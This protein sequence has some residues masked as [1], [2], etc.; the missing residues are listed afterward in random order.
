MPHIAGNCLA[1]WWRPS[2]FQ[3]EMRHRGTDS[4]V[5]RDGDTENRSK[6]DVPAQMRVVS[7]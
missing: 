1:A 3:R 7:T 2:L 4:N 6:T 5:M